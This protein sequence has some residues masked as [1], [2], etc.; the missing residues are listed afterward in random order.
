MRKRKTG[1]VGLLLSFNH[2][3][4]ITQDYI[5]GCLKSMAEAL[6]QKSKRN[7]WSYVMWVKI[8]YRE[9]LTHK[10]VRPYVSILLYAN[11]CSE[12]RKWISSYW[13]NGDSKKNQKGK[14]IGIVKHFPIKGSTK[15]IEALNTHKIYRCISGADLPYGEMALYDNEAK[16]NE[17]M[18]KECDRYK[19]YLQ[20]KLLNIETVRLTS[21]GICKRS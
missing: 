15:Y 12:V 8:Y 6:R 7:E 4:E 2:S 20:N 13:N 19:D 11:P 17:Y 16:Y 10:I 1:I 9:G 14:R 5:K 21:R 3:T 18:C